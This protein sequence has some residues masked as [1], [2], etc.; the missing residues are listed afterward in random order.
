MERQPL[1]H[2]ARARHDVYIA[3]AVVL[4]GERD[5]AA[6]RREVRHRFGANA[7]GE[8]ARITAFATHDPEVAAVVEDDLRL[9]QRGIAQEERR[10]TRRIRSRKAA[11]VTKDC[12]ESGERHE[13]AH[14]MSLL[15]CEHALRAEDCPVRP[16]AIQRSAR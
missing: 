3:I 12:E 16:A 2:A 5:Q 9:T 4:A 8:L 15:F 13:L 6:V 14:G 11:A 1:R 7:G 10:A